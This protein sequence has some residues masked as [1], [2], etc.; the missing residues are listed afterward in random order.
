VVVT[1]HNFADRPTEV[2]LELPR[3][4]LDAGFGQLF[5][6]QDYERVEAP[7]DPLPVGGYGYRWFRRRG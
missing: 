5:A 3:E 6:D 7:G 1:V 4:D 2:R